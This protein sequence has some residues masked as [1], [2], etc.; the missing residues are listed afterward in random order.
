MSPFRACS[1]DAKFTP[2]NEKDIGGELRPEI[3]TELAAL[4]ARTGKPKREVTVLDFGCGRGQ[5]VGQL[6]AQ[7][8]RAFGV[9]IEADFVA[10]GDPLLSRLFEDDHPILSLANANGTVLYPDGFFD[11]VVADQVFEHVSDLDKVAAEIGRVLKPG[12]V[13]IS[14]FPARFR[15]IEP[16]YR[17]PLV[18]WLRKGRLQQALI[19]TMVRAGL[20]VRPPAGNSGAAMALIVGKYAA[21]ETFYRP[22]REI[23]A[24][25]ARHGIRLDF[26]GFIAARL[27]A[28]LR[29]L[30]GLRRAM[31][32]AL[33]QLMPLVRIYG[34]FRSSMPRGVKE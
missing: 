2:L 23:A 6:R 4:T 19:S 7:G 5:L 33:S 22:N 3:G 9:E 8:W 27:N 30:S 10:A 15:P 14:M 12:G 21:T 26:N 20:G 32:A 16:H 1:G 29:R 25:F 11:I 24:I 28:K 18:H 13:L 31:L 34:L 17:L